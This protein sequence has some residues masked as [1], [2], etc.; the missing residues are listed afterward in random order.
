M[1]VMITRIN[2]CIDDILVKFETGSVGGSKL[3]YQIKG[4]PCEHT[5]GHSFGPIILI[6]HIQNVCPNII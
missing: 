1:F 2:V 4:K 3:S 6:K 5:R